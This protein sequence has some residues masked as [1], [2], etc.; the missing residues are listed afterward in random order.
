MSHRT[1]GAWTPLESTTSPAALAA[2]P[3]PPFPLQRHAGWKCC[4]PLTT[5]T[6][7]ACVWWLG[8]DVSLPQSSVCSGH[9]FFALFHC[10]RSHEGFTQTPDHG[11]LVGALQNKRCGKCH[12][13]PGGSWSPRVGTKGFGTTQAAP[14][15]A[16]ESPHKVH[17]LT[18]PSGVVVCGMGPDAATRRTKTSTKNKTKRRMQMGRAELSLRRPE[19]FFVEDSP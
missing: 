1:S 17:H 19:F 11:D 7:Q 2:G 6:T 9:H 15:V 16:P 3:P 13:G 4:A 14:K 5:R 8:N 12:T 18:P 10:G